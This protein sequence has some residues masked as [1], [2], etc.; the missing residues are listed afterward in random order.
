MDAHVPVNFGLQM[1]L[2]YA[3]LS[4]VARSHCYVCVQNVDTNILFCKSVHTTPHKTEVFKNDLQSKPIASTFSG[5][6]KLFLMNHMIQNLGASSYNQM[7]N[8]RAGKS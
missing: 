4:L 5:V 8:A 1:A 6:A 3:S 7:D 2:L